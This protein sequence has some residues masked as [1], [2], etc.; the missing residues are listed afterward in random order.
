[1]K[2]ICYLLLGVILASITSGCEI[3][4]EQTVSVK[5]KA[6]VFFRYHYD[7]GEVATLRDIRSMRMFI[8]KEGELYRDTLLPLHSV[9]A[10]GALMQTYLTRGKYTFVSWANISDSISVT[11]APL[12]EA[13][14]A[15][16]TASA[17]CLM[18]GKFE[19]P[20]VKG[21]SLYFDID[22]FKSVFKI[23]VL[24]TGLEKTPYPEHHFFGIY[25]RETLDFFNRPSGAM[26]L[27]HPDL[28]YDNGHLSGSFYTPYF[29]EGEDL[30]IGIYCDH[31]ESQYTRLCETT[32]SDFANIVK[33]AVGHDV[34]ID[35]KIEIRDAGI[36]ITVSDWEG[37]I[38]QDEHLGN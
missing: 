22:L 38:I 7:N 34:E 32:I 6:A 25:N 3:H 15:P 27:Y 18:Y 28:T 30:T 24:V 33:E 35:V 36:E 13:S 12:D 11:P 10:E 37:T 20:V 1:M 17:G 9:L 5:R 19:T 29:N 21:D 8:Y 31:P 2:H 4:D 23:N 14:L 16:H 26:K